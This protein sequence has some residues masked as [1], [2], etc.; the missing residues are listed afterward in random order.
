MYIAVHRRAA[1]HIGRH[2][3]DVVVRGCDHGAIGFAHANVVELN[4]FV[5]AGVGKLQDGQ[6]LHAGLRQDLYDGGHLAHAAAIVLVGDLGMTALDDHCLF[7]FV[8]GYGGGLRGGRG[9]FGCR[10]LRSGWVENKQCN[11]KSN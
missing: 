3:L 9:R 11:K 8:R 6:T 4:I 1:S 7:Q 10:S 5:C 2:V